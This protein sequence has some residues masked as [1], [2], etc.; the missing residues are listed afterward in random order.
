MNLEKRMMGRRD[1]EVSTIGLGRMRMSCACG[2]ANDL[3]E[4]DDAATHIP[5]QGAR[6][7]EALEQM[8][9]R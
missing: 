8:T 6:H 9:G 2:S 5:V 3:S 7:P 1:P 4:I